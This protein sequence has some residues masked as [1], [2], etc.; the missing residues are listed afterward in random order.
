MALKL[1]P[2]IKRKVRALGR[3]RARAVEKVSKGILKV[4]PLEG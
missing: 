1:R 4:N 3:K 2:K